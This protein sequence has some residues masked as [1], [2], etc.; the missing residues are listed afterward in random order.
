MLLVK[1]TDRRTPRPWLRHVKHYMLSHT[2]S[3]S[4]DWSH[5]SLVFVVLYKSGY[6]CYY[7]YYN[8]WL[9]ITSTWK[10]Q[11][12]IKQIKC[13]PAKKCQTR[14]ISLFCA[15]HTAAVIFFPRQTVKLHHRCPSADL[16]VATSA[17][18]HCNMHQQC[19]HAELLCSSHSN[20]TSS[21]YDWFEVVT[22]NAL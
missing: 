20:S 5:D 9:L 18:S 2:K 6:Y 12:V 7:Y 10:L 17:T 4:T 11:Q 15:H 14:R 21:A 22:G 1:Q 3:D 13:K 19:L 16:Q 8:I